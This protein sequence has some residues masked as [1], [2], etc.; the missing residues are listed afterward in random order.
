MSLPHQVLMVFLT[1]VVASCGRRADVQW[2]HGNFEVYALDMDFKGT[3][4][5]YNHHPG[6]LGLVSD[7]VIAAGST[8]QFVFVERLDPSSGRTEFYLVPKEGM[9]ENHSGN[10][11][12]PFSEPEFKDLRMA[13]QL[14]EFAWRKKK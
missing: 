1:V 13:R 8:A 6:T 9:P 11:E 14:P 5:G 4:L 7:E 10:V 2:R 12:G 3:K